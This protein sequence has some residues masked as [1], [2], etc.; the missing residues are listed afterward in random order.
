MNLNEISIGTNLNRLQQRVIDTLIEKH[1]FNR[2]VVTKSFK[3]ID[4]RDNKL[5]AFTEPE[6][7]KSQ[8]H[9]Y[10]HLDARVVP[11][12]TRA[13][14][15]VDHMLIPELNNRGYTVVVTHNPNFK[16][17][18]IYEGNTHNPEDCITTVVHEKRTIALS[19]ACLLTV[20][21]ELDDTYISRLAE[22]M[23]K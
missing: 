7:F 4:I 6:Q 13:I 2:D 15:P 17:V 18:N 16:A 1:V 19:L 8:G 12:Y 10:A 21:P 9:K 14:E 5:I 20:E 22:K 3:G 23:K 11:Y